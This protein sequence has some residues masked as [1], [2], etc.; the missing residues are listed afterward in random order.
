MQPL[1]AENNV[2]PDR[3]LIDDIVTRYQK[4]LQKIIV[5]LIRKLKLGIV[6]L[7]QITCAYFSQNTGYI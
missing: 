3:T 4:I 6:K 1:K 7:K 5:Y 2:Q